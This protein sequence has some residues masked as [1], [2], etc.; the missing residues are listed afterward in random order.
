MSLLP[1]EWI[2]TSNESRGFWLSERDERALTTDI[3][4]SGW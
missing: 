4:D 3:G 2:G 1:P